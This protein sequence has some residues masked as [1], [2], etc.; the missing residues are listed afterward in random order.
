MEITKT[1]CQYSITD[2]S[3]EGWSAN[4]NLTKEVSGNINVNLNVND[5]LGQSV[6]NYYYNSGM[7][8]M[9]NI[10]INVKPEHKGKFVAYCENLI[11]EAMDSVN[12]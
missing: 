4:G 1:N 3:A 10:N 12:E 9:L 2:T 8:D 11:A 7:S 6:G 5:A